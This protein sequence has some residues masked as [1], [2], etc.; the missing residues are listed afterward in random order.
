M[1][2]E[3]ERAWYAISRSVLSPQS[4]SSVHSACTNYSS[5][6]VHDTPAASCWIPAASPVS[7]ILSAEPRLYFLTRSM[8][9]TI[10]IASL[11]GVDRFEKVCLY[12]RCVIFAIAG[13]F[14]IL[15]KFTNDF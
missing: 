12:V 13:D 1:G 3:S 11:S 6:V 4:G 5:D 10:P 14:F 8:Y 9:V 2:E 15:L 7:T